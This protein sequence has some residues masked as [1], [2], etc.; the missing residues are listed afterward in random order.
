MIYLVVAVCCSLGIG[1]IFKYAALRHLDRVG[2]LTINYIVAFGVA[3]WALPEPLA[4]ETFQGY[5]WTLVTL[6]I[7]LGALFIL[8]FF[9]FAYATHRVGLA[10]SIGVMR[11]SV[12]IPVLA[13]WLIWSETPSTPQG[14]GLLFASGAFYLIAKTEDAAGTQEDVKVSR[15]TVFLILF[16]LF[17]SGGLVD[18]SLKVFQ[19]GFAKDFSEAAFLLLVFGVAFLIGTMIVIQQAARGRRYSLQLIPL[20]ILLGGINYGAAFFLLEA[21]ERL[22]GPVVFPLNS[23]SIVLGGAFLGVYV[24]DETLSKANWVGLLMA[25]VALLLIGIG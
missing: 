18:I 21:I 6:G 19:E 2:L 12:L 5:P 17:A 9:L 14:L 24:W 3:L 11:I 4:V 7:V 16:S 8:G 13:S 25:T 1:I 10:L 23:I 15:R 22:A 20:G